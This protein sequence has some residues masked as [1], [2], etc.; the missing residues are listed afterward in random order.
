M[1]IKSAHT[2]IATRVVVSN[3]TVL[4][5]PASPTELSSTIQQGFR[6]RKNLLALQD[7]TAIKIA[8]HQLEHPNW[9]LKD[10]LA[11][12]IKGFPSEMPSDVLLQMTQFIV[13][14]WE[15]TESPRRQVAV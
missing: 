9:G 13:S 10:L 2:K 8:K 1:S 11:E 5:S 7:L 15:K 12:V 3:K 6:H 4:A 14:Q